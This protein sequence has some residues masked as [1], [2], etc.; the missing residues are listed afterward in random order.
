LHYIILSTQFRPTQYRKEETNNRKEDFLLLL[1]PSPFSLV[2]SL[3]VF[4]CGGGGGGNGVVI[5]GC[6]V[7][8]GQN[9]RNDSPLNH[10]GIKGTYVNC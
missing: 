7:T 9:V 8:I 4:C 3:C 10:T 1:L 2:S 5:E 6:D